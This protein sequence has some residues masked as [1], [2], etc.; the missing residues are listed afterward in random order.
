MKELIENIEQW[1]I[2]RELDKKAWIEN[3]EIEVKE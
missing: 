3:V 2:D 1:G